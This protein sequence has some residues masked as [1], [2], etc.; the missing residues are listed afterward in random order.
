MF[1]LI[2][3]LKQRIRVIYSRILPD[4][5]DEPNAYYY[6]KGK[7]V[8]T[9]TVKNI[10]RF[11]KHENNLLTIEEDANVTEAATKMTENKIGCLVVLN[12]QGKLSGVVTERDMLAKVL[13]VSLPPD[14][15]FVKD[16]MTT[17]TIFCDKNSTIEKLEQIMSGNSIRHLPIAENSVPTGMISA[18]DII[19]Y[20]LYCN[21]EMKSAAEQLAMLSAGLKTL[22]LDDVIELAINEVPKGFGAKMAVLCLSQKDLSEPTIYRNDCYLSKEKLLDQCDGEISLNRQVTCDKVCNQ[23]RKFGGQNPKLVIP[24]TVNNRYD[25]NDSSDLD[26]KGFLCMCGFNPVAIE[27]EELL[28]YRASLLQEILNANLTSAKLFQGYQEALRNSQ[29]DPLTGVGTRRVLEQTLNT[30]HARAL[31]YNSG[32]SMAVV[33]VDR[34]KEI[35][36]TAGHPTGDRV[37]RQIAKILRRNVRTMD[38]VARYGGDEFVL[39]MPE[40]K[41]H[42]ARILLD[43][44]KLQITEIS[45]PGVNSVTISGGIA[46]WD[47][48]DTPETLFKRADACLYDAKKRGTQPNSCHSRSY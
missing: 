46:E 15:I 12:S 16:I 44:L 43:R 24:L 36:D 37:L 42:D 10:E 40:T 35:N 2:S 39:L 32:F 28:L 8:W 5:N 45:I 4:N 23:C 14:T 6:R 21:E 1:Y 7:T 34:L 18:R 20:R 38:I 25:K 48:D 31:R 13:A 9:S 29:I 22:D 3:A 19:A 26:S 27:S 17:E 11:A 41:L 47:R 33:D 30:E